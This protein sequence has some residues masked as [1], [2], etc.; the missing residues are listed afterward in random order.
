MLQEKLKIATK[1]HHDKLEHLMFVD[2]I[3]QLSLN[4]HQY[5]QLL[6]TNYL[7]HNWYE[8]K[9][10][11]K[12]GKTISKSLNLEGRIK[13]HALELDLMEAGIRKE[14]INAKFKLNN[15]NNLPSQTFAMGALYVLEGA[16]LGGS[17]IQKQLA[18]NINFPE[19]IG[20]NYYRCYGTQLIANW[21]QFLEVLNGIDETK[22]EEALDGALWMFG[23]IIVTAETVNRLALRK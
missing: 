14:V 8:N 2:Q 13:L 15:H 3:M 18:Q 16:T 22:H 5:G 4:L 20:H 21:K 19:K 12:I 10:H 23:E 17:V 7:I 6:T 9:L 1:N 11:K